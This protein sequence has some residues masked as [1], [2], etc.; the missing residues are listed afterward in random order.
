MNKNDFLLDEFQHRLLM[1]MRMAKALRVGE[2][3]LDSTTHKLHWVLEKDGRPVNRFQSMDEMEECLEHLLMNRSR[4][5][6]NGLG[7][8]D[9]NVKRRMQIVQSRTNGTPMLFQSRTN[10]I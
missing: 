8:M 6:R 3:F 9:R 2:V 5:C 7:N 1:C 4:T 10:S